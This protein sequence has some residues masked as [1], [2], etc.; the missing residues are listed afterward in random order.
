M[1]HGN[2]GDA[3]AVVLD[4]L[5]EL[6]ADDAGRAGEDDLLEDARAA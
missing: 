3:E 5:H 6:D 4:L 2:L 1:V